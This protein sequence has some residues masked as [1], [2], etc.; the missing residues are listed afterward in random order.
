[1]YTVINEPRRAVFIVVSA[2]QHVEH[3]AQRRLTN[4]AANS[5]AI[6]LEHFLDRLQLLTAQNVAQVVFRKREAFANRLLGFFR[7]FRRHRLEN[8]L[9]NIGAAPAA[10]G[11]ARAF[12]EL[13][14]GIHAFCVDSMDDRA[15]NYAHATADGVA[16]RHLSDIEAG[17]FGRFGK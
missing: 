6:D 8:L 10:G 7:K 11:S 3:V 14:K 4:L 2:P 13:R 1:M 5:I 17:I 9:A 12:L 16:V 15:F